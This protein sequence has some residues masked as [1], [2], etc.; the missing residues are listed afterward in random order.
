MCSSSAIYMAR[1]KKKKKRSP[2]M[3]DVI[4]IHQREWSRIK[5]DFDDL[6]FV[7]WS[8]DDVWYSHFDGSLI[9]TLSFVSRSQLSRFAYKPNT[10]W[11]ITYIRTSSRVTMCFHKEVEFFVCIP[12]SL[13]SAFGLFHMN[14]NKFDT[15]PSTLN[16]KL[17]LFIS[18]PSISYSKLCCAR[19]TVMLGANIQM[20]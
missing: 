18:W 17:C 3:Y 14:T 5:H 7:R 20:S 1:D 12:Q 15:V 6:P 9:I 19:N 8:M 16:C 11:V 10:H 4:C 13:L 2:N